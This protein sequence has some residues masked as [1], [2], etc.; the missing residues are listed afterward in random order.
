MHRA[1]DR[2][3][4]KDVVANGHVN[5][6]TGLLLLLE[7]AVSPAGIIGP[8]NITADLAE[9]SIPPGS[10]HPGSANWRGCGPD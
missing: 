1:L 5:V 8:S 4:V 10:P 9:K 3:P 6:A 7:I 2:T